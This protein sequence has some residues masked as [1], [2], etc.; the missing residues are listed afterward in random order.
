MTVIK[1]SVRVEEI[2]AALS[3]GTGCQVIDVREY[4]EYAAGRIPGARLI[5]LGEVE[6]R[7]S[8]IDRARPV[9]FV[10]RTGRRSVEAQK[11]LK[12]LG[13]EEVINVEGGM[14]AWEQARLPVEKEERA[15]WSL[16]RQ[17]RF[18]AG[19]LVLTGVLLSV[20]VAEPLVWIAG[21]V[22]AG[23][24][25]AAVTDTCAMGLLLARLPWNRAKDAVTQASC[26]AEKPIAGR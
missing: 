4:P 12:S 11:K 15:P 20:L 2:C 18:V 13:F 3:G 17:V 9:Y 10:C 14:V 19:L 26:P 1:D 22:G 21:F 25:F 6:R 24:V 23:L 5:P 8:E 16:E 7:A